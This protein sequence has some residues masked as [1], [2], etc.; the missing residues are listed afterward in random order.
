MVQ[1][2]TEK[3]ED[4]RVKLPLSRF[5]AGDALLVGIVP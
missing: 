4:G 3:T 1:Q 5:V 2:M